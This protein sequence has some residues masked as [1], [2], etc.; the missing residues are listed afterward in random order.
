MR[1]AASRGSSSRATQS[2]AVR[3]DG[4]ISVRATARLDA[5]KTRWRRDTDGERLT[6]STK[7]RGSEAPDAPE[8]PTTNSRPGT[9]AESIGRCGARAVKTPVG[10]QPRFPTAG[11]PPD[12]GF[13]AFSI[14]LPDS[15]LA[16]PAGTAGFPT[17]ARPFTREVPRKAVEGTLLALEPSSGGADGER[18]IVKLDEDKHCFVSDSDEPRITHLCIARKKELP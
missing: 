7:R 15:F 17:A 2:T 1:R 16:P 6:S 10:C 9:R 18:L 8:T 3:I 5:E 13:R 4:S 11:A 14:V 12:Q